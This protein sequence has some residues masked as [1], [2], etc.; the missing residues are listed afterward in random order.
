MA[1]LAGGL[2][3]IKKHGIVL[4]AARG[5]VPT[6]VD[7]AARE[8]IA[9]NWWSHPKGK[10]IFKLTREVRDSN[11]ILVCKLV[12]GKVTYVDRRIW[13]ALVV[14]SKRFPAANIAQIREEHTTSGKHILKTVPFPT[15]VPKEIMIDAEKLT[16]REAMLQFR[17]CGYEVER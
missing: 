13:P 9:G 5:A 3:F 14:L 11:N 6:F 12:D 2:V 10:E 16:E 15:W 1:S 4:E 7:F 17:A 8:R